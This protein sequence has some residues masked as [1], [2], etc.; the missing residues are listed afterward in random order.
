MN[1]IKNIKFSRR[2]LLTGLGY[3]AG[4]CAGL[5]K[6]VY[7]QTAPRVTR[8][9]MFGYA[10]GSHPDSAPTGNG[11]SFVLSPHM[12]PLEPVRKDII[13]FRNMTMERDG[14][15]SHKATSFSIFGLGVD[16]SIDQTFAQSF[17]GTAPLA[18]LEISIGTTGGDGGVIPGLSQLNGSFL[19]GVRNPAA[20]YQRIADR[21]T[22]GS[23]PPST[24]TPT[25]GTASSAEIALLRRKSVLDFVKDDIKTY[26]GRLGPA[27]KTKVDFY[28]ES[29][30]TL[31]RDV[32]TTITPD[33]GAAGSGTTSTCMQIA[34]P[35]ISTN[36]EMN[37]MEVHNKMYLDTIALAF[38]CNI[39]RVASGMWGGGENDRPFKN[40]TFN[41]NVSD[42]HGTSHLDP[43]GAGQAMIRIQAFMANQ[44]LYLIQKLKSYSDGA[45][46][47]LDN[48]ACVLSTQNGC[49]T[50]RTYAP[51]DHPKQNSPF[52]V[53]GSCGGAW[54]T[55]R[56]IDAG[57]R[58]HVDVYLS[59]AK[60][61]GMNVNSVGRAAWC[62]GPLIT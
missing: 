42:W 59:I 15:N 47:L 33:G 60:A 34:A 25:M 45:Y 16:T 39:T 41:I 2:S 35:T 38:A 20:A 5:S 46:S 24:S 9:A 27:E 36:T 62:K 11:E 57:G 32:T 37:D 30:R 19:P 58:T 1:N 29:L 40:D 28:L 4:F 44:F 7:A 26:Q 18:S 23:P 53:A 10:N 22:G 21:I 13:I 6:N 3:G 17:K 61:V 56:L 43:A 51:S 50:Q 48:T 52:I 12:A 49:S 31:E 54:K 14:S 55:G 8:V